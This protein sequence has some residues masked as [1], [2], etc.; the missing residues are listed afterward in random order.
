M[1]RIRAIF[2]GLAV[3][4]VLGLLFA[5]DSEAKSYYLWEIEQIF[6]T[7]TA[8]WVGTP[9]QLGG[10]DSSGIDCS[11]FVM[12][13]FRNTFGIELPRC[14]DSQVCVGIGVSQAALRAGDLV[15]FQTSRYSNHVGIYLKGG[16][17]AHTSKSR[18]VTISSL[19]DGYWQSR[20]W[21][22]R[23]IFR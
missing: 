13:A 9:Y 20:Y 1:K 17:F 11:A 10:T 8:R 12:I 7:E 14:T 23:R 16:E 21:T 18:G 15:F 2:V 5:T 19:Y 3:Y 22:A 4:M 6:R